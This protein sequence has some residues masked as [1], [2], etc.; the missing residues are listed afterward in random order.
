[1]GTYSIE[2]LVDGGLVIRSDTSNEL[3]EF[4]YPNLKTFQAF[5]AYTGGFSF[6]FNF[7][8]QWYESNLNQETEEL[9][10]SVFN[11][12]DTDIGKSDFMKLSE[13]QRKFLQDEYG[14]FRNSKRAFES[15]NF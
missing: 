13:S 6:N 14:Y 12:I 9:H 7:Y 4:S 3:C 10:E 1:M 5:Y 11:G 2:F 8:Q 15:T